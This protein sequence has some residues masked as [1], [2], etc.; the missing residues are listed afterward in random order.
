MNNEETQ[1]NLAAVAI[2][3]ANLEGAS[4]AALEATALEVSFAEDPMFLLTSVAGVAG[5]ALKLAA[6]L[7]AATGNQLTPSALLD[8]I[9]DELRSAA[10]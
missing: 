5:A 7:A 9:E 4:V 10:S 1:L 3:R 6:S 8:T 2:V